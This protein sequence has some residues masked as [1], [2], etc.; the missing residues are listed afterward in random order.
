M[1]RQAR[2]EIGCPDCGQEQICTVW[3]S[4]NVTLHPELREEL[5]DGRLNV[6]RCHCGAVATVPVML[7]YHDMKRCFCISY[8]PFRPQVDGINFNDFTDEGKFCT[9]FGNSTSAATSTGIPK[10]MSEQVVVFDLE[11]L[12]RQVA[13]REALHDHYSGITQRV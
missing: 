7:M 11:E 4:I 2:I 10:Y 12:L 6:F 13:F 8:Y 9:D 1:S 5:F 3:H